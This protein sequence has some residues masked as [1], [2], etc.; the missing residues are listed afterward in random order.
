M[1]QEDDETFYCSIGKSKSN[2]Y[3]VIHSSS[4]LSDE[5]RVLDANKPKGKWRV[6][7]KREK[8]LEYSVLH[9]KEHFYILTNWAAKN[10]RL[11]KTPIN[12]TQKQYWE[13]VIAH[14]DDI[15]LEGIDIFKDYMVVEERDK[16]LNKIRVIRWDGKADYTIPV[17]EQVYSMGTSTNL[18]FDTDILRYVYSSMTTPSSVFDFNMQNKTQKLLKQQEVLGDFDKTNY[19]SERVF[20]TA[21]DGTQ[22]PISLVFRKGTKKTKNTPLLLYAYGSYGNTINPRFSSIRLSLIDR[23]FIYAIAHIRGGQYM[24]RDW[25]ENGKMLHK[26]NTFTDYIDCAKYLIKEDYTSSEHIYAM[27]GSAGGLL[28]GAVVNMEPELFNGVIAG[29]PFVDVLTTMLDE[30][31]PLTTFEYDEWGNPNEKK[32]YDYIKSYSPYDNVGAKNYPNLLVTTGLHD[33]QVQYWEPAKWVAKL[34]AY[35]T[36]HNLLLLHTNMETGH[37]GASGRFESLKEVAMEY[38]FFFYLEGI[39]K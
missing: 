10:F 3:L 9:Y 28:M 19:Q 29:V 37:G 7:Q 21:K 32:Y 23:G 25:Y 2:A 36:N 30:S 14:R 24:G 22:I 8:G 6:I 5:Y 13:E 18:D 4:T 35:R 34:R 38:A 12:K 1:Y 11:M 15:L 16:G 27:G 17:K 39:N 26:K 33:S 31:I 20:A